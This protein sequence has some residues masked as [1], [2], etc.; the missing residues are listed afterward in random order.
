MRRLTALTWRLLLVLIICAVFVSGCEGLM[1][2]LQ[3]SNIRTGLFPMNMDLSIGDRSINAA[4]LIKG[5]AYVGMVERED[6]NVHYPAGMADR[7]VE[8]ADAFHLAKADVQARTGI[9][10]A[11]KPDVYL[12]PISGTEKG[13][14]LCIPIRKQRALRVPML[15]NP[16]SPIFFSPAWSQGL[17]HELTEASMLSALA[18]RETVLGDYCTG[19]IIEIVNR[20]R[21]FRD[22]VSDYAGDLMN[23]RLF[24]D[25]YQPPVRIYHALM[26]IRS[27]VLDWNN[28]GEY[29]YTYYSAAE[30]LVIQL[31]DHSGENAIARV[32]HAASQDRYINGGTLDR[33]VKKVT[34][35]DLKQFTSTYRQTWLGADFANSAQVPGAPSIVQPGNVVRVT[36]V[37]PGTPADKWHLKPG[38]V[39]LSVDGHQAISSA[40][41][42]HYLAAHQPRERITVDLLIDGKPTTYHMV[43]AS[44][45]SDQL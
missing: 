12:V 26:E 22:G 41:L 20:A 45:Y 44:R 10:W 43:T 30:A 24:G 31:V 27:G 15:V 2:N 38:D 42:V 16:S 25:R 39:I 35:L 11:F 29:D 21:W 1:R 40:W 18:R 28:C 32:F 34:S 14:R 13:F 4:D 36:K 9:T 8:L 5:Q 6:V 23:V 7:A 33:A 37:Y 17:A 19:D 3:Y